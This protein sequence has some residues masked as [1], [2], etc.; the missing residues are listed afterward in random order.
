MPYITVM[1]SPRFHQITL[2]EILS[3]EVQVS[4]IA[5]RSV[6][7]T[8]THFSERLNDRL[9]RLA[10][11]DELVA[12]LETFIQKNESLYEQK[13]SK[14]YNTFYIA[15]RSGGLRKINAPLE[16]LMSA[17]RELKEILETK[18]SAL[19][20]TSAF[21]YVKCRSTVDAVKK[22]QTNNSRWF[23]K[24]DF[25]DFFGSTTP[26]FLMKMLS[27][28]Y[29]FSEVVKLERGRVVLSKALD[30]CF[31]DGGLPQGTPISPMLTNL[32]MIPIDHRIANELRRNNFVDTRYADDIIISHKFDFSFTEKCDFINQVLAEFEAP[33]KIKPSK[34]RYGSSSGKNWNLGVML[35]KDNKITIGYQKKKTFKAMCY[36]YITSKQNNQPWDRHDLEV[37][38]GLISYYKMV[39]RDYIAYTIDHYN[40]KYGVNMMAMIREDLR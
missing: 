39:E 28:I 5:P 8:V 38:N 9:T 4:D 12:V 37:F 31:L 24:T 33:F 19:Y 18:F 30:L 10:Q 40:Q 21:A 7:G 20:H 13:R 14:L 27:Q 22:H 15:K 17:L 36:G 2:D 16:E 1:Q 3:G 6:T 32:M 35:N 23:L 29:P 34:T 11:V 25:S 26:E